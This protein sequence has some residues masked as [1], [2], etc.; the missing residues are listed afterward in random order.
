MASECPEQEIAC[1]QLLLDDSSV[2]SIQRSVFP[3]RLAACLTPEFLLSRYLAYIR[4]CTLTAVRP[5]GTPDGIEF[6]VLGSRLSLISFRLPV[7]E[8]NAVTLPICGGLLVQPLR[9]ERGELRLSAGEAEGGIRV[10]LQLSGF[11][12]LILGGIDPA[13][14][15]CWLYRRTQAAVHR[16]VT[17]RFLAMLY[18]SLVSPEAGNRVVGMRVKEGRPL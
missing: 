16:L 12:P 2:F 9:R 6:R 10:T 13:P 18:R 5:F 8:G 1:Q 3:A 15:R 4:S 7:A 14:L 17:V 11:Y